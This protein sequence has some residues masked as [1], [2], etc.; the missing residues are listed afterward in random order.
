LIAGDASFWADALSDSVESVL[1]VGV[2]WGGTV[3]A[4]I[5]AADRSLLGLIWL[6]PAGDAAAFDWQPGDLMHRSLLLVA[7]QE[8][9]P[10]ARAAEAIYA[11]FHTTA[12][13]RFFTRGEDGCALL[14]APGVR[15]GVLDW[16][17]KL[18][19]DASVAP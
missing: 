1:V 5:V 2:G 16:A 11:R 17:R 7:T 10:S 12:E 9:S 19:P 6:G 4:R 3:A 8:D 14:D 13:L 15:D 18:A